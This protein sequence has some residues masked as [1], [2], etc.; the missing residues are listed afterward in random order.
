MKAKIISILAAFTLFVTCENPFVSNILPDRDG[1]SDTGFTVTFDKNHQ[2][3]TGWT[4][5][6]PS[7]KKVVPPARTID[8]LPQA[9]TR[10]GFA[11]VG[12]Y[13]D[14]NGTGA[15]FTAS[16]VVTED[17]TVY[18]H[19]E[20]GYTITFYTNEDGEGGTLYTTRS[21]L[22]AS[23]TLGAL[24]PEE[25]T[26]EGF[27]FG[28]W[29]SN[30][31]GTGAEFT[32]DTE[33]D[34][35][36]T[37]YAYWLTDGYYVVSY[38]TNEDGLGGTL[39][40]T[41]TVIIAKSNTVGALPPSPPPVT[42]RHTFAGWNTQPDGSGINFIAT[43]PVTDD[44]SVYAQ[45]DIVP[46]G[47]FVVIFDKNGGDTEADPRQK[48]VTPPAQTTVGTLPAPPTRA[49][50]SFVNWNTLDNGSGAEFTATTPVTADITVYAKWQLLT[51]GPATTIVDFENDTIGATYESTGGYANSQPVSPTVRVVADPVNAGG[52]SLAISSTGW[53][54]AAIIP[55]NLS[56]A[57]NTAESFTF[58]FCLTEGII[59]YKKVLVYAASDPATFEHG[60]FG[61]DAKG[62][63]N[64]NGAELYAEFAANKLGE[65]A[66]FNEPSKNQW[67]DFTIPISGLNS[68]LSNLTGT[69]YLAIG[70]HH[71]TD[72][73][74]TY[75]LDNLKFN[76]PKEPNPNA[77]LP[78][79]DFEYDD[80]GD[81]Y[82]FTRGN[83]SP[84]SVKVVSDPSPAGGSTKSLEFTGTSGYNQAAIV[85]I[86]LPKTLN[87]YK[88]FT[89][90]FNM[91]TGTLDNKDMMVY[92][93]D[94]A[95]KFNR[96]GFGNADGNNNFA[97]RL[98]GQVK[99]TDVKNQWDSYAIAIENPGNDIKDLTGNVYL[100]IGINHNDAITYYL[101]DLTFSDDAAP[102]PVDYPTLVTF[103]DDAINDTYEYTRGDNNPTVTVQ[104]TPGTAGAST[105][106]LRVVTNGGN[107]SQ[108]YNQAAIIP[109]NLPDALSTYRSFRFRFHYTGETLMDNT[110]PRKIN[111]YVAD[112]PAKF[113][114]YGFGNAAN[115]DNQFANLLL[116]EVQ[117]EYGSSGWVDYAINFTNPGSAISGLTG[118][119]Y[120][121]IG[122]NHGSSVTYYLDDLT[123]NKEEL[124]KE[125]GAELTGNLTV[126]TPTQNSVEITDGSV[127]LPAGSTQTIEYSVS[128]TGSPGAW[129]AGRT[130]TGLIP[131]T[132]YTAYA[133]SASNNQ[134][135]AGAPKT[136]AFTTADAPAGASLTGT[137]TATMTHN[138][139]T[140]N[141]ASISLAT[142]TGQTIE[143]SI[144][145]TP[146]TWQDSAVF[147]GLTK[148]TTYTVSA[149]SKAN[150]NYKAGEAISAQ[151]TTLD[152]PVLN[153]NVPPVVV[154]FEDDAVGS[155]TKYTVTGGNG[156]GTVTIVSDPDTTN[157]PNGKSLNINSTGYNRGAIIPINLPFAL[158]EY[159]SFTFRFRVASG[160]PSNSKVSVYVADATSK[161]VNYGFGNP[162]NHNPSNQQ[163]A[164]LLLGEVEPNYSAD[165]WVEY[166]IGI[167]SP[168]AAISTLS[169][170]L[171]LAIGINSSGTI[172]LLFDDLTFNIDKDFVPTPQISPT[173]ATF[174][175]TAEA[176]IP[177]HM[178]L[179]GATLQAIRS[180][181]TKEGSNALVLNTDYTVSGNDVTLK[182][183]YF[184]GMTAGSKVTLTFEFSNSKTNSIEITLTAASGY[185]GTW[186][187]FADNPTVPNPTVVAGTGTMNVRVGTS[188]HSDGATV[189]IVEKTNNNYSTPMFILP[190]DLGTKT[191]ADFSGIEV[192]L[193][194]V[195]GDLGSKGFRIEA[196]AKGG[197]FAAAGN[198]AH[199]QIA[200]ATLNISTTGTWLEP[201]FTYL[202][203]TSTLGGEIQIAFSLNNTQN[204]IYEIQYVRLVPKP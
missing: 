7:K 164:N 114:R 74:I 53:N 166:E 32:G 97:S 184:T 9:P 59:S 143:Y 105:K 167:D 76:F 130:F 47:S 106:S 162:A 67:M 144:S 10:A 95:D 200:N 123:F 186:Y 75:L 73:A 4:D 203:T 6:D 81:D 80:I 28:G 43:T 171:Y 101:D 178:T 116:G 96:Y 151:F 62:T 169:G 196:L 69:I 41:H 176:D 110:Q 46:V 30:V 12:W 40:T 135:N 204:F 154:N 54:Q 82:E 191:L 15:E 129:Q 193:R 33:V 126:G 159:Q 35:D 38:Y 179:Y 173:A 58:K 174:V 109:I 187:T 51:T 172:T 125:P 180:T 34:D 149:R 1:N 29:Y 137:M 134:Y 23:P 78:I 103:E 36:I 198:S 63:G 113:I 50:Y 65:T 182:K 85:P 2:D 156:T 133:R 112:D 131:L 142:A 88:S 124:Q 104:A 8:A 55:I 71:D 192:K 141:A 145:T 117:P 72:E 27:G 127:T 24:M 119:V 177:V 138:R 64:N 168:N 39:H 188:T 52:K 77:L 57:L 42:D 185:G 25:P 122:I 60:G 5:A 120:V 150:N 11:F 79:V 165:Q 49:G 94:S 70:I 153:P 66:E 93:A 201:T 155:T 197:T 84:T 48:I 19:W 118:N 170:N 18:A 68:A 86:H 181:V 83:N 202:P 136:V 163:F 160:T 20:R 199:A 115:N 108:G 146:A 195:S 45:W 13:A 194:G 121:A 26:R 3:S 37:L 56:A 31:L 189:L 44:I 22:A 14:E 99:L 107:G 190:F 61:N 100:A 147:G 87:L 158:N 132:G 175:T 152:A 21:V 139:I 183:E 102:P 16:T 17:I 111:V 89:F 148:E 92:V 128:S 157:H 161:F 98:L 91:K 90:R 140:V